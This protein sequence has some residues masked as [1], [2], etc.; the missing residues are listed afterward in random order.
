MEKV[1]IKL[2]YNKYQSLYLLL[3]ALNF[4]CILNYGTRVMAH[5]ILKKT[6]IKISNK[7]GG[8]RFKSANLSL[9]YAEAVALYILI[10]SDNNL[11]ITGDYERALSYEILEAIESQITGVS[12]KLLTDDL[13]N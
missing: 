3:R 10:L 13:V 12:T 4:N 7:I 11:V 8:G 1:K 9:N 6:F 2:S 5:Y